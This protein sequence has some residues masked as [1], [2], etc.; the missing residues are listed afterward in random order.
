MTLF[1]F[2]GM[3]DEHVKEMSSWMYG[4]GALTAQMIP[5]VIEFIATGS[6]FSAT[7]TG[8]KKLLIKKIKGLSEESLKKSLKQRMAVNGFSWLAGTVVHT[9]ANP[10]RYLAETF[11]N[12]TPATEA[13]NQF[14]KMFGFALDPFGLLTPVFVLCNISSRAS[15]KSLP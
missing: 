9:A 11:K 13:F 2:Q 6:A 12:M 14:I 1:Q 8:T 4:G 15:L 7:R 10:Q 3:T 5:Y